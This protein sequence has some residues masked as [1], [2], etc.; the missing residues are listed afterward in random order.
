[1]DVVKLEIRHGLPFVSATVTHNSNSIDFH[2]VVVD[3]GSVGSIFSIDRLAHINLT[4]ALDDQVRR[5][6]GV[7]GAEF[8]VSKRVE[9]VSVEAMAANHLEIQ[10][11]SVDYG[12]EI[13][14]ILGMDW[15]RAV[16]AVIDLDALELR[17]G[18]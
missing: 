16:G 3:T 17:V 9:Q 5:V 11:G 6:Q 14:G 10:M 7:A 2:G 18:A 12:F 1:M 4:Y 8:V 15:L 13:D